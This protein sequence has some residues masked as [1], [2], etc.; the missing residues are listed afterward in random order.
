MMHNFKAFQAL[1][2]KITAMFGIVA[3]LNS[4]G[5][6]A[7]AQTRGLHGTQANVEITA[8]CRESRAIFE[9]RNPGD[10]WQEAGEIIVIAERDKKIIARRKILFAEGQVARYRIPINTGAGTHGQKGP[11]HVF[12]TAAGAAVKSI[13][14]AR[15]DCVKI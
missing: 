7:E 11:V 3:A 9:I 1:L 13:A 14:N 2:C 8:A 12:V 5:N 10:R 6:I 4:L 15:L